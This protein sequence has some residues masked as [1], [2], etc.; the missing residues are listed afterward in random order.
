MYTRSELHVNDRGPDHQ[1][2]I[3]FVQGCTKK[4]QATEDAK[5]LEVADPPTSPG[6]ADPGREPGVV[7]GNCG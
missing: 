7:R 6:G 4:L 2:V 1:P 5:A 3:R